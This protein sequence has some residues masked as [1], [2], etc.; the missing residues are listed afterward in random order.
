MENE[1]L[2]HA[3]EKEDA[4]HYW[5]GRNPRSATERRL[6]CRSRGSRCKI[7]PKRRTKEAQRKQTEAEIY[8]CQLKLKRQ[9]VI[10]RETKLKTWKTS[11]LVEKEELWQ[12]LVCAEEVRDVG[13]DRENEKRRKP[14]FYTWETQN[15]VERRQSQKETSSAKNCVDDACLME[16]ERS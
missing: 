11:N 4:G 3:R 12:I 13:R 5:R 14:Q 6:H 2:R 8:K 15:C 7:V 1:A 9:V 10:S 16:V